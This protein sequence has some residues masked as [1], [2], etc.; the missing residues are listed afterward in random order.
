MKPVL[1]HITASYG[2]APQ[3]GARA[4][5][6]TWNWNHHVHLG[7]DMIALPLR[8]CRRCDDR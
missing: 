5:G 6:A 2:R 3:G 4:K 7:C 1:D 8:L